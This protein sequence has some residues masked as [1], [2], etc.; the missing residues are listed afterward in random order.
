[1]SEAAETTVDP[2]KEMPLAVAFIRVFSVLMCLLGVAEFIV[3]G[4]L[5]DE[6]NE[7]DIGGIYFAVTAVCSGAWGLFMIEGVQQFNVLTALLF[8]NLIAAIVGV[9]YASS[10]IYV[11]ERVKACAA[12][13]LSGFEQ[14]RCESG[15]SY[16]NYTCTGTASY[17]T[18]AAKCAAKYEADGKNVANSCGCVYLDGENHC[19][20]FAGFDD[21]EAMQDTVASLS[22]G[23]YVL[24]YMCLSLSI[25]LLISSVTA[26]CMHKQ[27]R[28]VR[29]LT[30][31]ELRRG[32]HAARARGF[33][34]SPS[35]NRVVSVSPA[36]TPSHEL[37]PLSLVP[38]EVS[39]PVMSSPGSGKRKKGTRSRSQSR[40]DETRMASPA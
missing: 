9:V 17:F 22:L 35:R 26:S 37:V 5:L 28:G 32:D 23:T 4:I 19:W 14:P 12:L 36:A 18:E 13:D 11:L 27:R 8:L 40:E 24:G 33:F 29:G 10:P 6:S 34:S 2:E 20:E 38:V 15:G 3:S 21:C 1:M 25:L 7:E 30:N 39:P 16:G 31:D